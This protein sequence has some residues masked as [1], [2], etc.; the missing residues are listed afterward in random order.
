MMND[1]KLFND[2]PPISTEEWEKVINQDLK[3]ADYDKRLIW[4]TEDGFSVRP[5]YRAENLENLTFIDALPNEFPFVRGS[6][7]KGNHW[8]IMQEIEEVSPK[9]ANEIAHE[10]IDKGAHILLFSAKNIENLSHLEQM[11]DKL[12][13]EACEIRFYDVENPI[14]FTSFFIQFIENNKIKKE[15]IRVAIECDPIL[16]AILQKEKVA[17]IETKIDELVQLFELTKAFPHFS[18][19]AIGSYE[20]RD[21]G[22]TLVQ[23]VAYGL[24]IANE[25]LALLT[26]K[27]VTVD[28]IAGKM[29]IHL[30]VGANYFMEIA[31]FRA[32]RMLWATLIAQYQPHKKASHQIPIYAKGLRR[33]KTI[34]DPYVNILRSTTEGMA[35]TLGGA[36][37]VFLQSFDQAYKEDDA[38]SRRI[39]RNIQIILKE[40]AFFDKVIDPAAGSY[41]IENL[42]HA[43]AL[44]AWNLF[45]ECVTNSGIL[46]LIQDGTIQKEIE[47][48]RINRDREIA[49]RKATLVGTNQ[50]P[51]VNEKM[52]EWIQKEVSPKEVALP[53]Y[54][55]AATFEEIRLTTET[56]TKK[57]HR[58]K[59][60]LLKIGNLAFRQARAG[61]T[62]N[63]FG[64]AGFEILDNAGFDTVQE[65]VA[66]ALENNADIVVICS[67]DEE[68]ATLG[69]EATTL[70]K[71]ATTQT[72]VV[73]AGN[74]VDSIDSLKQA[75]VDD[76]IHVRTNILDSL[77]AFQTQLKMN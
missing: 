43:I 34:Y 63:F 74:P 8:D 26:E 36:D 38:F 12:P 54:R 62:T 69:I 11:L 51:N 35:A 9:K 67:S 70:L 50:Y 17:E 2:F 76:F 71:N 32:I 72:I 42:T 41:Y 48:S 52:E 75:G 66:A 49:T 57:S 68:Y 7:T 64:C 60:F 33:N 31:K 5:Y 13:L 37:A 19:L 3:G 59:V 45:K 28:T 14:Q 24:A 27:G 29:A 44:H 53:L 18:F 61:F 15:N 20:L 56:F 47:A 65:G 73:V 40:E 77:K 39:S 1:E 58:P 6:K 10:S 22:A 46:P 21:R 55:E 16:Q 25:Y 23:E 30:S 4:K